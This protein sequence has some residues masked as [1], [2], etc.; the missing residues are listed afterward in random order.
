MKFPA[1]TT[2]EKSN[3]PL[4]LV[5]DKIGVI[6][7]GIAQSLSQ[8]FMVVFASKNKPQENKNIIHTPFAK[9]IPEVPDNAY[10][11][12]FIVDDGSSVTRESVFSF[13]SLA[14]ASSATIYFI[15][16]L[17]NI[18]AEHAG[19]VASEYAKVKVLVFG[20]LFDKT[21]FFDKESSV[22][23]F[24]IEARKSQR[25]LVPG[26]GLALNFP[27]SLEDT[28]KLIIKAS[29][30]ELEQKIL[31]LFQSSPITDISLAHVFQKVSP[32]I[33]V[34]FVKEDDQRRIYIPEGGVHVISK[35]DLEAKIKELDLGDSNNR[36]VRVVEEKSRRRN[37]LKPLV[38]VFLILVFV[39]FLPF[40]TT[41]G[42]AILGYSQING[43]KNSLESGN[44]EKAL[45]QANNAKDLFE[46]A[47]KTSD[48]LVSEMKY[49]GLSN[50]SARI[51]DKISS[52]QDVSSAAIDF[53]QGGEL[54]KNI[55]LGKSLD[56]ST[57]FSNASNS[58]K[59][60]VVIFQKVETEGNLPKDFYQQIQGLQPL[61]DLFSNSS[62]VAPSLLGFNGEKKYLVLFQNNMELRPGGGFI[63]SYGVLIIKNARVVDFKI[64]DVYTADGQLKDHVEPPFAI[65][66]ILPSVHWYLRDSNFD[67]D[68]VKSAISASN[69]YTLETKDK[70]DGVIGIDLTFAKDIVSALGP[71]KV[72]DYNT[73]IDES[74]LFQTTEQ[75]AEENFFPGSTQKKDFLSALA[76]SI[77]LNLKDRK[78]V[79]YF[80]LAQKI[81]QSL[82]QKD[83]LFAFKDQNA[84]NVFTANDWSG[85]LWDERA[86][87][88]G[89]INDFVGVSEAN[90]GVNK[91]NYYISRSLSKKT[92]INSDGTV[93]SRLEIAYKNSSPKNSKTG[94]NYKNY[95]QLVLPQGST[96]N[97]I[98]INDNEVKI[99][100]AV[101]DYF[102]YEAKGFKPP[103]GLEVNQTQELGK[104]VFGFLVNV[105]AG[106]VQT[107]GIDYNLPDV[108][109]KTE[110]TINYSL[111]VYKQPG[112]DPFPFD[113][114]FDLPQNYHIVEGQNPMTQTIDSDSEIDYKFSQQ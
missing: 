70:V 85:S 65:R 27:I 49:L 20:D 43:A 67:P 113:L 16:S 93:S 41:G 46:T 57:D 3:L 94:G 75:Q 1:L 32:E 55:Y 37:Y 101:T 91:V 76:N 87:A 10:L 112:V 50:E 39:L 51:S 104:D 82:T 11:K 15:A 44:L 77:Q 42:Y 105:P 38:L 86:T 53:L 83:I 111:K 9:K 29:Y 108:I 97:A 26:A 73:T 71:T 78:S 96:L 33:K 8:D 92:V 106:E 79:P 30:L 19:S 81:G 48:I 23:K 102:V 84:Q 60:G 80:L 6:G 17:R 88:K 110:N 62:G 64:S 5:V 54:L 68:F 109:S 40:F 69:L 114:S 36:E 72:P 103:S 28:I 35:Y 34:D 18:D 31:L 13:V 22:S 66:R 12:L 59:A 4:V 89:V 14:R 58:L 45:S 74:N 21:L 90:L 100:K 7:E 24:I 98:F 95:I 56:P 99:E 61:I 107:I 2:Q 25:I 47:G 52:A 63:G